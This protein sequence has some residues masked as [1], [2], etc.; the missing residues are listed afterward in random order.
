MFGG[1]LGFP[2]LLVLLVI[3]LLIFGPSKLGQV[4]KGLGEAIR[5]FKSAVREDEKKDEKKD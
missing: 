2:E 5:N 4:G 1:K 3:A